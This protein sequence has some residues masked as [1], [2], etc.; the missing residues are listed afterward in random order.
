MAESKFCPHCG[1]KY[2]DGQTV[3]YKDGTALFSLSRSDDACGKVLAGKFRLETLLG[4]G[5]FGAV[6]VATNLML[7]RKDAIKVL[8][9][10]ISRDENAV[11]RF[12]SEARLVTRLK[13]PHTVTTYDLYHDDADGGTLML[14]MELLEGRSLQAEMTARRRVPWREAV[15]LAAQ[16]CESLE[17]AHAKGIVH[18]DLKPANIMLC[19]LFGRDDYVKVLD[20]GIA[21]VFEGGESESL[22]ATGG[23]VGTP[24]YMSPEHIAGRKLDA[25]SDLYSLGVILYEMLSG[26]LPFAAKDVATIVQMKV[27]VPPMPLHQHWQGCDAPP[28]LVHLIM[29]LL[30]MMPEERPATARVLREC[31]TAILERKADERQTE[32]EHFAL[33]A[34]VHVDE[35]A[36][37]QAVIRPPDEGWGQNRLAVWAAAGGALVLLAVGLLVWQPWSKTMVGASSPVES[38]DE[39][40]PTASA[41]TGQAEALP[42]ALTPAPA[43]PAL[44]PAAPSSEANESPAARPAGEEAQPRADGNQAAADL[45][46]PAGASTSAPVPPGPSPEAA[47]AEQVKLTSPSAQGEP[48]EKTEAQPEK[49]AD[50]S[51]D[52]ARNDAKPSPAGETAK[53]EERK[54]KTE[55]PTAEARRAGPAEA[56]KA[57]PTEAAKAGPT[58]AAKAGPTEAAKAGPAEAAKAGPTEAAKPGGT[59]ARKSNTT[60]A[61]KPAAGEAGKRT[62]EEAA[63][64]PADETAEPTP[65]ATS[66]DHPSEMQ[67]HTP[68]AELL[69][70][71]GGTEEELKPQKTHHDSLRNRLDEE[72]GK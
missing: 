19:R 42:S 24:A 39:A 49:P 5:G 7:D 11:R 23:F 67:V 50:S 43:N 1:A 3:C 41:P 6:Y 25:R 8:R 16:V 56:A 34:T 70:D 62:G 55:D 58:E 31:L 65:K 38:A 68:P 45:H 21:K 12:L 26:A 2:A 53:T 14:A 57:G 20:F 13:S 4:T 51:A 10:E 40:A 61:D 46:E 54:G 18:R 52:T 48:E 33:A 66:S 60:M 28:E 35:T 71:Q 27:S 37:S 69:K 36:L 32:L 22:T 59:E 47:G 30:G 29:S 15:A 9:P 64:A 72:L 17:E 44:Q 63:K